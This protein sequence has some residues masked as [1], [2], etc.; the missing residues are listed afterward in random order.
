MSD[1]YYEDKKLL[2]L[3]DLRILNSKFGWKKSMTEMYQQNLL[4]LHLFENAYMVLRKIIIDSEAQKVGEFKEVSE[5]V[6]KY[7]MEF[8]SLLYRVHFRNNL[9][10]IGER[11]RGIPNSEVKKFI[12]A[13][14]TRIEMEVEKLPVYCS[15]HFLWFYSDISLSS[16]YFTEDNSL[17][18]REFMIWSFYSEYIERAKQAARSL[19]I[20]VDKYFDKYEIELKLKASLLSV[21]NN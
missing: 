10:R 21:L 1:S 8:F 11:K 15:I 6:E 5:S 3:G 2:P 4:D 7:W 13:F 18:K 17:E 9:V 12:E 20:P 19:D 16:S 14:E